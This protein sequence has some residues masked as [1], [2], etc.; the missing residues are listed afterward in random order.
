MSSTQNWSSSWKSS[1][2]PSKQ[3]KYRRNAPKHVEQKLVS[4]NVHPELRDEL[5]TRSIRVRT[6][7]QI[8]VMRGDHSGKEGIVNEVDYDDQKIYA[9]N[10]TAERQNGTES[11]VPLRPSNVRIVAMNVDDQVRME[12]FDVADQ[13]L[14]E[15]EVDEEEMEEALE[16]DE[17]SEMMKQM[18]SGE[19]SM[20]VSTE[21]QDEQEEQEEEEA[22]QE[23]EEEGEESSESQTD[24]DYEEVVS[25]TI[26]DAKEMLEQIKQP[27]YEAALE[28]E[29]SG[30]D[31][32]T[33]KEWLETR[34]DT[35]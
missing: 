21:E 23:T 27:D 15:I 33:L 1:E 29:K 19:S 9:S 8:E 11:Q 7:D 18:Q 32:K 22:E 4:A 34:T 12:K 3:R 13:D 2:D 26:S 25:G 24:T 28:A 6:G 5:D 20:D 35:E 14:G 31:R 17:E 10:I 16:E 30:K